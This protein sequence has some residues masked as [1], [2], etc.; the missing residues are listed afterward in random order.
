MDSA[1]TSE[2]FDC[3]VLVVGL[4]PV[5]AALSALLAQRGVSHHRH[6]QGCGRLS[7]ASGRA[8][9]S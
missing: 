6:R 2:G 5:G 7:Y 1:A 4:G 8:F 3:D 9:R